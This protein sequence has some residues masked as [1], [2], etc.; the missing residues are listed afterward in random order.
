MKKIILLSWAVLLFLPLAAQST[1]TAAPLKT[2]VQKNKDLALTGMPT[3]SF[4]RSRGV[5][6]G[7][8]GMLF[9]KTTED[10]LTSPSRVTLYGQ[11]TTKNNWALLGFTQLFLWDDFVRLSAGGGYFSAHFQTYQNIADYGELVEIP[12]S[13]EGYFLVFSPLFQVY[14]HLFAGPMVAIMQTN[15]SFDLPGGASST[16][17]DNINSIGLVGMYDTRNNQYN[18]DKGITANLRYTANP[19]FMGNDSLF[20]KLFIY[21]NYYARLNKTMVLASRFFGNIGLGDLPFASQSYVGGRDLRGYTQ[22]QY[23]GNQT[24]AAQTELRWNFY[25]RWGA[26]GFFG[27]AMTVDPTSSLLP[28]GGVGLRFQVIPKYNINLGLDGALGKDDWGVYFR[29]TEAF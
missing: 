16:E 17:K 2:T 14:K 19:A 6:I 29:I 15:L 18:P 27:L 13:N 12:Y 23:R 24:Y 25:K 7:A 22:G 3:L 10:T 26:V 4:N 11:Y 21:V 5:G 8:L 28:G 9:F 20:N 1:D